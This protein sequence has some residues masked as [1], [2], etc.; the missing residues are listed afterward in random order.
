MGRFRGVELDDVELA[1]PRLLLRPW[2]SG[3]APRVAEVMQHGQMSRFLAVP[4]PYT[5]AD[6][7]RYVRDIA[8]RP[9]T[10]GTG[11]ECAIVE[12]A[13][14]WLVG[15][16][17][18]RLAGDPEVGYWVAP[19]AQG[20]GYAAEAATLLAGWA[21]SV[22]LHRVRVA[23]HVENLASVRTALA[24]GFRFEGVARN[25]VLGG[26][27][28]GVPERRGD[29][30]R[31]ARLSD[32]PPGPVPYALPPLPAHGLDDGV[33]RLRT[34]R[35]EDAPALAE[36]DD[37]LTIRWSFT[38]EPHTLDEARSAAA[39]AGLEWLVGPVAAFAMVD[40]ATGRFAGSVRLRNTGPPQVGGIGYVVHPYFR[41]RGYTTRALRLLVSWAFDVAGFARLE[42]GAKVGNDASLRAAGSAGFEPDG[43]RRRR[44]RNPDG[45]F[46][47]EVRYCLINPKYA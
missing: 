7:E 14:G 19:D 34:M 30:A 28:R 5:A 23:C 42:L 40:L 13:S 35:A 6:A 18:L 45:T 27:A 2:R 25:G 20:N 41:G 8:V 36:T 24:A 9:R 38:G 39:R 46:S 1:G 4:S 11:L 3:D 22:G 37:A 32:D 12:S 26:G 16:A 29:L 15:S 44:L 10:E 31:F 33:L 17:A 21:F 47:D 43:I